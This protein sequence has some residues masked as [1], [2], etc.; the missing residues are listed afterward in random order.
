MFQTLTNGLYTP[1]LHRVLNTDPARSRV[2]IPFFY[3]PAFEATIAPLPQL[4][5]AA[6]SGAAAGGAGPAARFPSVRYG[7]HLES[8]VLS[9]FEL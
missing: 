6:A 7:S 1:T 3:E 9:N 5:A 4:V 8:K 2:S